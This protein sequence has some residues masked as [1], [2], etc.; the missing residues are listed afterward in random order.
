MSTSCELEE[1]LS[2][3][4]GIIYEDLEG[5]SRG[6][7]FEERLELWNEVKEVLA[8]YNR[9]CKRYMDRDMDR[10]VVGKIRL[11][12]LMLAASFKV[13]G[14]DIPEITGRFK[15]E[16][17][18]VL[19]DL[20]DMK[21][22][23]FLS[24]D[25]LVEFIERREGKV[26]EMI[27][28]YYERGYYMLDR[29]WTG[30]M[31][32]LALALADKY[33]ER[34]RKIE[35]AVIKYIRKRPL[36][37]FLGEIEEA[38][39]KAL[40]AGK[41]RREAEEVAVRAESQIALME[42][43][44]SIAASPEEALAARDEALKLV[45]KL[46]EELEEAREKLRQ[47]EA[48]LQ[49]LRSKYSETSTAR[50]VV[51][52]EIEALRARVRELEAKLEEYKT[53]VAILRAEKESLAEH[54]EQLK[55]G[56]EGAGEGNLV[57]KEEAWA[58]E[59]SLVERVLR[60]IGDG[61][62]I[63]DPIR[64]E[65]RRVKW[66]RKVYYSLHGDGMP[67]GK[68]VQLQLLKGVIRKKRDVVVDVVTLVHRGE[69]DSRGW[70]NKPATLGEV[71]DLVVSRLEEAGKQEYYHILIISSPT[72]FTRKA[73]DFIESNDY[74]VNFA[75]RYVTVYLVDPVK[76]KLY[77]N[78]RDP[79]A[80]T[81]KSI[82]EPWLEEERIRKVL[83]YLRSDD[84]REKAVAVGGSV[85]FLH[86]EDIMEATGEDPDIIARAL[87]RAEEEGL[88]KVLVKED[89]KAFFYKTS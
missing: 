26:Y 12:Q 69:F 11:A 48:E 53:S 57:T 82:A 62:V 4:Y 74:L 52:A 35:E 22:I 44:L 9:N 65:A 33:K 76:G 24:V 34:R 84:A 55:A 79:A 3:V 58:L 19:F 1:L 31:G 41:A 47:K 20:E 70:D 27:K 75:S 46:L 28:N 67:S 21:E 6:Y 38:V 10:K 50:E 86:I 64:K 51:D 16:E 88:G 78:K 59:N 15:E 81:N 73:L 8:K 29:K 14:E 2:P 25:D 60:R 32:T 40:D 42:P 72:G 56:L 49:E 7:S 77:Y 68:G 66:S 13:N 80:E 5:L 36:T 18:R 30:M 39:K 17:Y 37:V 89:L 61:A 71:M 54:L 23:D 63:Y 45:E 85:P 87:A 43:K 83:D